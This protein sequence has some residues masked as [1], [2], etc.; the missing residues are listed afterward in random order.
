[1]LGDV[2]ARIEKRLEV[3]NLSATAASKAA[4]LSSEAI[5]N[6]RRAVE[7]DDRQGVSTKTLTALA[8]VLRTTAGWLLDGGDDEDSGAATVPVVGFVG[9]GSE[10][11]FYAT[12]D[13]LDYVEAPE[14][15]NEHTRAAEVR[16]ESL[17]PLFDRWL[18]FYDDVRTPVTPDLIGKLCIVGLSNDKVLVKKLQRS[19]ARGRFNLLSNNETPL[20]DQVVAWAALVRQM[21]PR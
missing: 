6:I 2:L 4:G 21:T 14:G 17:G 8:P 13:V 1:M 7:A 9:A 10:A 5:R 12:S 20:L 15:S 11:H 3:V 18:I 16:G 19:R